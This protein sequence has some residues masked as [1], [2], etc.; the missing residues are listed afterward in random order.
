MKILLTGST[1]LLGQ[2]IKKQLNHQKISFDTVNHIDLS[3]K[4]L[5]NYTSF[6]Y[7]LVI[8]AAARTNVE[9]CEKAP[10]LCYKDNY[11]LTNRLANLCKRKAIKLV[12][13]SSTGVYGNYKQ[14]LYIEEDKC[15]PTTHHHLS[16]LLSEYS[17]LGSSRQNLVIRTGWLFGGSVS[18]PKNFVKRIINEG[19]FNLKSSLPMYSNIEQFGCP[20]YT[21]D[22]ASRLI[23]LAMLDQ[24][25]IFNVVNTSFSS[26]FEY[27]SEIL[28][29]SGIEVDLRTASNSSFN[30]LAKV[31][32][33]ETAFNKKCN[34]GF[35]PYLPHWKDSLYK[36]I[37][38][39]NLDS[40]LS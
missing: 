21:E 29:I 4:V 26:R 17:V 2:S 5:S 37:K 14:D 6:N 35:L 22:V 15:L 8:H 3:E 19:L 39:I 24:I 18:N 36:Y 31:S 30:R 20:S 7:D 25:G 34:L 12:Y 1:G 40:H 23:N 9:D 10:T 13:V 27:V 33:N 28:R 11:V 16:K 38:L 32:L